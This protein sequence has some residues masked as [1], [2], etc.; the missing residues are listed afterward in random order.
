[1]YLYEELITI[2]I[3]LNEMNFQYISTIYLRASLWLTCN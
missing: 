2:H 3:I 1:M